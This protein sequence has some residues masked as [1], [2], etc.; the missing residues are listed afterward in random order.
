MLQYIILLSLIIS[1]RMGNDNRI[2]CFGLVIFGGCLILTIIGAFMYP[3]ERNKEKNYTEGTC[4]VLS[5]KVVM[6]LC[7][8]HDSNSYYPTSTKEM[9]NPS[10]RN[11]NR[12]YVC[13]CP[14]WSVQY[15]PSRI[16]TE[17]TCKSS[18]I[19]EPSKSRYY[20]SALNQLNKYSVNMIS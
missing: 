10:R 12:S 1:S 5:S 3:I 4:L 19:V 6:E 16:S 11:V 8:T 7:Y 17:N 14:V 9:I 20:T 2:F 15:C 18:Q 13:Y